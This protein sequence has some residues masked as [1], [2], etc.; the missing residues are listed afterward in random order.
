MFR[1]TKANQSLSHFTRHG[2]N[3]VHVFFVYFSFLFVG[4]CG[5]GVA[6]NISDNNNNI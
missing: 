2:Q 1:L 3:I 5:D 6:G 4:G